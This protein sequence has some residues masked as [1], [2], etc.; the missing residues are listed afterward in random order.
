MARRLSRRRLLGGSV[1]FAVGLAGCSGDGDDESDDGASP[2]PNADGTTATG[3]ETT[4]TGGTT[5][6][7]DG[8]ATPETPLAAFPALSADDPT[9][10]NWQPGTGDVRAVQDAAHG[11]GRAR[12]LKEG[13]PAA[14]YEERTTWAMFNGYVGVEY[15]ELDGVVLGLSAVAAVYV[16]TFARA[17]VTDRLAEAPYEPFE[18][19][20]GV[21]YYRWDRAGG[22]TTFVGVGDEGVVAGRAG[23]DGD[24]PAR[25]FVE[26]TVPLFSTAAGDRP[27]LHEES[28]LYDRYTSAVGWP[29]FVWAGPPLPAD[30]AGGVG[31]VGL[32]GASTLPDDVAA[33]VRFGYGQYLAD[34]A[35]VD[36]YWLWVTEDGPAGPADVRGTYDDAAVRRSAT[37]NVG[38]DVDLAVRRDGR[39]VEV[40]LLRPVDDPGGGADP[41]LVAVDATVGGG[42]LTLE[43][44]AGDSLPLSRVTVRGAGD[45][46]SLGEG[47]L[48]P[49]ESVSTDMPD[50]AGRLFV[51]YSPPAA[52]STTT[53]ART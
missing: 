26:G 9:Y 53:I 31:A 46:I 41:P 42:T 11:I 18:T 38:E 3:G 22:T 23:S 7:D 24:D 49:G 33:S 6:P 14:T 40:G 36:R 50:D 2:A 4:A 48:S 15:G 27:R 29:L 44:F 52:E 45:P 30:T 5:T 34:G 20:E 47:D 43:H 37:E 12:D 35:L 28:N 21:D 1:P 51:V 10:R 13:L 8:T 25:R 32:P 19:A 39:V 17:D 16:G